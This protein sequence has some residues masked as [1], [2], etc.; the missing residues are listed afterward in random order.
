MLRRFGALL[1]AALALLLLGAHFFRAGLISVAAACVALLALLF[2]RARWAGGVLQVAL[3][4]GVLE[5]LRAAWVFA[6]ARAAAGQPYTRLLVI[7]GGVALATA[8][9]A[10][11]LR[12]RAAREHFR[13]PG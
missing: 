7:L 9:A 4:L 8:F 2:V 6:A 1:L 13:D 3:V 12:T 11:L 10:L 5:W